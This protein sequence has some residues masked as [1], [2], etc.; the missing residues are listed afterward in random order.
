[1]V[2]YFDFFEFSSIPLIPPAMYPLE[3]IFRGRR[4]PASFTG[5]YAVLY[6]YVGRW[7]T[8]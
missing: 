8:C 4:Q 3:K 7:G 1:M 6:S 2:K 5:I